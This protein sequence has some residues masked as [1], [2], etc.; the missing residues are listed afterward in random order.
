MRTKEKPKDQSGREQNTGMLKSNHNINKVSAIYGH[1]NYS[2]YCQSNSYFIWIKTE[3]RVNI[4]NGHQVA[5]YLPVCM[6]V[7]GDGINRACLSMRPQSSCT[8]LNVQHY[9]LLV[10]KIGYIANFTVLINCVYNCT[11]NTKKPT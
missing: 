8:V 4:F 6:N 9:K 2:V 1:R 10:D 5:K 7:C 3:R 11:D